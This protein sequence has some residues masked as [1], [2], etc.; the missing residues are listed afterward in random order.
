LVFGT[1]HYTTPN[2]WNRLFAYF[3]SENASRPMESGIRL[4][5]D[6]K[7]WGYSS[8]TDQ[9]QIGVVAAHAPARPGGIS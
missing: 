9:R 2:K 5:S 6:I 7:N 8:R 1:W 4:V 3:T